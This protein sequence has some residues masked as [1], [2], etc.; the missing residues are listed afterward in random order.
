MSRVIRPF[1]D[2]LWNDVELALR[3]LFDDGVRAGDLSGRFDT[4]PDRW[5]EADTLRPHLYHI[6]DRILEHRAAELRPL[7]SG[8]EHVAKLASRGI[9]AALILGR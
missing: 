3:R 6:R 1:G 2:D 9:D 7:Q 8:A 4:F 5:P